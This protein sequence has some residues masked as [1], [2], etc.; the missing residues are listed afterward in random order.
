MN[1]EEKPLSG[2]SSDRAQ[3]DKLPRVLPLRQP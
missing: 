2:A 1:I 3:K